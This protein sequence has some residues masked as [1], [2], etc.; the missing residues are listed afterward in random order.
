MLWGKKKVECPYCQKALEKKPSRKANCPF[1]KKYIFV[2]NR[3]LV[4]E[5]RAKIID[6]LKRLE[7]SE[8]QFDYYKKSKIKKLGYESNHIDLIKGIFEVQIKEIKDLHYKKMQYYSMAIIMNENKQDSFY[9]LQQAAKAELQNLKK[10][11][12][13]E[14]ELIGGSCPSC[15]QL[16]GKVFKVD[17]ALE[18]MPIP[19]KNCTHIL[20]DKKRGFCRC[21]YLAS[22][23]ITREIRKEYE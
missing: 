9:Y 20:Y 14:V 15:Q 10:M 23:E 16:K 1:C 22:S 21:L 18:Q 17:E 5:E 7:I 3:E 4:S 12:T 13:E 19:N 2:R 6:A 8:K 11:G